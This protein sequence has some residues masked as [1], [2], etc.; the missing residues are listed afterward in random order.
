VVAST[1]LQKLLEGH[2]HRVLYLPTG[3]DTERFRP[4]LGA[5]VGP[6]FVWTGLAWGRTVY[7]GLRTLFEAFRWVRDRVPTAKLLVIGGGSWM[8]R[9]RQMIL[10]FPGLTVVEEKA[11]EEMPAALAR[12]AVGVLPPL[13]DSQWSASKSP[14]KL[15]EYMA[16]G[17]AVVAWDGGEARQV[18]R[19]GTDGLLVTD[20]RALADA[21]LAVAR[22]GGLRRRLGDAARK[23]AVACYSLSVLTSRLGNYLESLG[24]QRS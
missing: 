7:E 4:A 18:V 13:P 20:G 10:G 19:D 8:P 22:D 21:M 23:R 9:F 3:V 24:V 2:C 14:T 12:A 11:P 1:G 16:A 6:V 15:F 17:L 5:D